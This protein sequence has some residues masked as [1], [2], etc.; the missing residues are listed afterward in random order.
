MRQ[1][2]RKLDLFCPPPLPHTPSTPSAHYEI[3]GW[4]GEG[5]A[6]GHEGK[7]ALRAYTGRG[8]GCHRKT[9]GRGIRHRLSGV[10]DSALLR[11][12]PRIM[13]CQQR[14]IDGWT[15]LYPCIYTQFWVYTLEPNL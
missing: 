5:K 14:A 10:P 7:V 13:L 4:R 15:T 6:K 1:W 8:K 3:D 12:M 2:V 9:G 11:L